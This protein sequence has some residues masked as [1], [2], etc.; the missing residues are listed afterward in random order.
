MNK[1]TIVILTLVNQVKKMERK[2]YTNQN[3][4]DGK[5]VY[6]YRGAVEN[7]YVSFA[8]FYWRI[9]RINED[10]SVRLIYQG[11][12]PDTTGSAATIGESS[13]NTDTNDNAYLGYMYGFIPSSNYDS[14]H[15]N[16]ND[17]TIKTMLDAWYRNNLVSYASYIADSGFCGDRSV[18]SVSQTWSANDTTFGYGEYITY[19]GVTNRMFNIFQPQYKCPQNEDLYTMYGKGNNMLSYPIGLITVDEVIYAGGNAANVNSSYYLYENIDYWTMSPLYYEYG[20][21]GSIVRNMGYLYYNNVVS[22]A[23]VRPVINLKSNVEISGGDGTSSN[24]YVVS[25]N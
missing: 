2:D 4:E 6:Y 24:P 15:A 10:K 11:E 13:F 16:V 17:S 21:F 5:T 8:D 23:G 1:K 20:A 22:T 19:Y 3:T 7:N 14:A 12:V 18:A 9:V 25:T